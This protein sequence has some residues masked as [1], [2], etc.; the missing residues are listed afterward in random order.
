MA[1]QDMRELEIPGVTSLDTMLSLDDGDKIFM[2]NVLMTTRTQTNYDTCIFSQVDQNDF[3]RVQACVHTNEYD[4]ACFKAEYLYTILRKRFGPGVNKVF[5]YETRL[6]SE[7][8]DYG[9]Q[10]FNFREGRPS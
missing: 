4:E 6:A 7:N 3:G 1:L 8:Y 2:R 10:L 9:W 5:D